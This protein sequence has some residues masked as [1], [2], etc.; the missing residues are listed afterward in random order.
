MLAG[1]NRDVQKSV[2]VDGQ[3]KLYLLG[4]LNFLFSTL[5]SPNPTKVWFWHNFILKL[6]TLL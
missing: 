3:F 6:I 5:G 1:W 4:E 2:L